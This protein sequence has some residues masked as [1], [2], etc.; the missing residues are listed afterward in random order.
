MGKKVIFS[1]EQLKHIAEACGGNGDKILEATA[2]GSGNGVNVDIQ[3]NDGGQVVKGGFV[4]DKK[5][6]RGTLPTDN[7]K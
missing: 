4:F 2:C 6:L 7:K 3:G 1:E 5:F